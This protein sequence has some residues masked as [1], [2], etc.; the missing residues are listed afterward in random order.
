MLK[1]L[2]LGVCLCCT[3]LSF[4]QEEITFTTD[5]ERL[6]ATISDSNYNEGN[7]KISADGSRIYFIRWNHPQNYGEK[8]DIWYSDFIDN[9]WQNAIHM[10][11][12][13]TNKGGSNTAVETIF[14]DGNTMVLFGYYSRM[15]DNIRSG[16]SIVKKDKKGWGY[17]VPQQIE[18]LVNKSNTTGYCL[19][20]SGKQAI[21]SIEYKGVGGHD[22][23]VTFLS[24]K[25]NIW[26]KPVNMGKVINSKG[27]DSTP[28]LSADGKTLFFSSDGHDGYGNNDIFMSKRM[29]DTWENWSKPINLGPKINSENYDAYFSIDAAGEYAYFAS[30]KNGSSDI[31]RISLAEEAKPDPLVLISGKVLNQKT[32]EPLASKIVYFDLETNTEIGYA[33]S[34]PTNGNYKIAL[35]KGK[36]YAYYAQAKDFYTVREHLDLVELGEYKELE[37]NLYLASIEKGEIIR[38]NNIFFDFGKATL[39]PESNAELDKLVETLEQNSDLRIKIKGHTDTIGSDTDNQTL[40]Q[41]RAK[42][43]YSYLLAEKIDSSRL[44]FGGYGETKPIDTTDTDKG[45]ALNRRVEFEIL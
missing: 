6:P 43:V 41:E 21:I 13:I 27:D 33:N 15:S 40:S 37:R 34:D 36:K 4:S 9:Q 14:P 24:K 3:L 25:K 8:H 31:Y 2:F 11:P 18:K 45:S 7:P 16:F 20:P 44:E 30:S 38:L 5:P 35:P 39:L 22:L 32:Q 10:Q 1:Q 26:S 29:D 17:P 19:A 12:P 23:Y 28:F 42:A